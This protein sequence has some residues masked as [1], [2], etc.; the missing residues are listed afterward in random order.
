MYRVDSTD[1][2]SLFAESTESDS[3][4][5]ERR[6]NSYLPSFHFR[7]CCLCWQVLCCLHKAMRG[8]EVTGLEQESSCQWNSIS[9]RLGAVFYVRAT[10]GIDSVAMNFPETSRINEISNFPSRLTET[11]NFTY[12]QVFAGTLETMSALLQ[13]VVRGRCLGRGHVVYSWGRTLPVLSQSSVTFSRLVS[14]AL[15]P[16]TKA[17]RRRVCRHRN[18]FL[19]HFPLSRPWYPAY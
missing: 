16:R 9:P 18:Y 7:L 3:S 17:S 15:V 6:H 14:V 10:C 13:V 11:Q 8:F 19:L 4:Q 5:S 2:L 12:R 1:T